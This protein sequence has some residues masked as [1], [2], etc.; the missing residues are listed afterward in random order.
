MKNTAFLSVIAI[1]LLSAHA[2][3][4]VKAGDY[5]WGCFGPQSLGKGLRINKAS[6]PGSDVVVIRTQ[7]NKTA[8]KLT[9]QVRKPRSPFPMLGGMVKTGTRHMRVYT[10]NAGRRW[11]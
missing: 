10:D 1:S 6:E 8:I 3:T 7:D 2:F 9:L 4:P 5:I 11:I